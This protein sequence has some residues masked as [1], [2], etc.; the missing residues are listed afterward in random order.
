VFNALI[1]FLRLVNQ[2]PHV[3]PCAYVARPKRFGAFFFGYLRETLNNYMENLKTALQAATL[4]MLSQHR[5]HFTHAVTLTMKQA[6]WVKTANGRACT[7][8]TEQLASRNLQHALNRL[9]RHFYGNGHKRKPQQYSLCVIPTL[10]GSKTRKRLHY[11]LQIGNLPENTSD[12]DLRKALTQAWSATDFGDTQIDI[13]TLYGTHWLN[14][15]TKEIGTA[16]TDCVDWRNVC[17]PQSL[18]TN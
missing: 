15:I 18:R 6:V 3:I 7:K 8:L 1:S 12:D 2:Q 16:D 9:N 4:H 17:I 5:Q 11:H 14:Y 10:E 13:Q